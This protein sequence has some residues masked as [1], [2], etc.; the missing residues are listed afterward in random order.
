M[1]ASKAVSYFLDTLNV[2]LRPWGIVAMSYYQL[3]NQGTPHA[4]IRISISA[5]FLV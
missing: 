4:V 5:M 2:K 3:I 1:P